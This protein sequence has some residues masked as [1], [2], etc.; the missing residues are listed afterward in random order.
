VINGC[1]QAG[2]APFCSRV[3][4]HTLTPERV[5]FVVDATAS[6]PSEAGCLQFVRTFQFDKSA[7]KLQLDDAFELSRIDSLEGAIISLQPVVLTEGRASIHAG[8]LQ[9]VLR[10]KNKT[11]FDRVEIHPYH[12]HSGQEVLAYRLVYKSEALASTCTLAVEMELA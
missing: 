6:Y 1:E 10:A 9:M 8:S 7:G 12:N 2:G 4:G 5:E 11:R 3:I